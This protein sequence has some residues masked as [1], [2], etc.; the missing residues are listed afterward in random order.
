[1]TESGTDESVEDLLLRTSDEIQGNI[2]AGFAK[3][4]TAFLFYRFPA[5]RR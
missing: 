1:M 3:D 4:H 5:L 2:L